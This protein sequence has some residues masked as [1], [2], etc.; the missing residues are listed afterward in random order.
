MKKIN[1]SLISIK[2]LK[3][4]L[5]NYRTTADDSDFFK[6][7]L[8][9]NEFS[10]PI[11][12]A[13]CYSSRI[14]S[15][16]RADS[17]LRYLN[18]QIPFK[19]NENIQ[20]I[21]NFLTDQNDTKQEIILEDENDIIDIALF[22]REFGYSEFVAPFDEYLK[23]EVENIK[24]NSIEKI[25]K[26]LDYSNYF[27]HLEN[28]NKFISFIIEHFYLY[29]ENNEFISWC[30]NENNEERVEIIVTS[31]NLK[32][33]NENQL[34]TFLL[35]LCKQKPLFEYLFGYVYLEYCDADICKAFIEYL[36]NHKKE[37]QTYSNKNI[38]QCIS[39]RLCQKSLPI[40]IRVLDKLRYNV[41][42]KE[43]QIN[44]S[45]M[46]SSNNGQT[47][48]EK[49]VQKIDSKTYK[50]LYPSEDST[51]CNSLFKVTLKAGNYKLEC[52]G[53]SGGKVNSVEGGKGGYSC[54]VLQLTQI[55]DLF[56]YIGGQGITISGSEFSYVN[57]G[58]NGGGKGE[59]GGHKLPVG[60]GGGATDIRINTENLSDRI[61]VAGGGGGSAGLVQNRNSIGGNGGGL[62]GSNSTNNG[63]NQYGCGATQTE[64]GK[65][66]Q[67][68]IGK[69]GNQN[70]GGDGYTAELYSS[71]GG[72][73]G[74][75][76]G[77][78]GGD[79]SGG[80]GGS[81]FLSETIKS[82]NGINK[83]TREYNNVG[84]GYV[85]ITIL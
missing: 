6:I 27:G 80:G 76:Y 2:F 7:S 54:G 15:M 78:S 70:Q 75:F 51:S 57:G 83:E 32:L 40:P 44:C 46:I 8:N 65:C 45:L 10:L 18:I 12:I 29:A 61:I 69:P 58:F 43:K 11:E 14:F 24:P 62:I 50:F 21:I 81:G 5:Y 52:V 66:G 38:L 22:G 39:R 84:N 77:G 63:S 60:S 17:M 85:I 35:K 73:G 55:A 31:K 30:C 36:S 64:A 74:G 71:A 49:Y 19:N 4:Y 33:E 20:K 48:P 47:I 26:L 3:Q 68:G 13:I 56:L 79:Y 34:L 67:G 59:T 25:L 72:G 41:K 16:I 9:G 82:I 37:F 53:A 23:N 42:S 1:N 28:V